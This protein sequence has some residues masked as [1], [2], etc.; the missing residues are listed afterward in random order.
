MSSQVPT[1]EDFE[2]VMNSPAIW[3]GLGGS[4]SLDNLL[5]DSNLQNTIQNQLMQSAYQA[6]T[7]TGVI[8]N[9]PRSQ[10]SINQGKLYTANGLQT[11]NALNV[12][13][14]S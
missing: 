9:V 12:L 10:V 4:D 6:L 5:N 11:L 13:G 2:C 3:T 1:Q 14:G 7:A 8:S